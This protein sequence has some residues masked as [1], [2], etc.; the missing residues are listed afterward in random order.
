LGGDVEAASKM[1]RQRFDL[2][3]MGKLTG[4]NFGQLS[5]TFPLAVPPVSDVVS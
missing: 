1:V 2:P 4:E 5:P 3:A